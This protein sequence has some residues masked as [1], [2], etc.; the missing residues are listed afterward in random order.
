[1]C[2]SDLGTVRDGTELE[3]GVTAGTR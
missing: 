2:S 1:V 3:G